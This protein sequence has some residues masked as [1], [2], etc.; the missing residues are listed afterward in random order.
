MAVTRPP[1]RG[2]SL[3]PRLSTA[4]PCW[5]RLPV[6]D[7]ARRDK[8]RRP[9]VHMPKQ[10]S[11]PVM[12]EDAF[13]SLLHGPNRV[14]AAITLWICVWL[15]AICGSVLLMALNPDAP[16]VDRNGHGVFDRYVD[17]LIAPLILLA[18]G[19][20]CHRARVR[21]ARAGDKL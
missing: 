17:P 4:P 21:K 1:G 14:D 2:R 8:R 18:L 15:F 10:G 19:L 16:I 5:I 13:R 20:V 9:E 6:E 3:P 12:L 11:E 7:A